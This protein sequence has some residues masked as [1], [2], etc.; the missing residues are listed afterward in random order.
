MT[1]HQDVLPPLPPEGEDVAFR[2]MLEGRGLSPWGSAEADREYATL[3][4]EQLDDDEPPLGVVEDVS[5][6]TGYDLEDAL[7]VVW[8]SVVCFRREHMDLVLPP[9]PDP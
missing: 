9:V 7:F 4:C 6:G 2:H 3:I 1:G 8:A 5:V